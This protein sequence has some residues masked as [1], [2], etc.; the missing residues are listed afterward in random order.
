MDGSEGIG[1]RGR[2]KFGWILGGVALGVLV[3]LVVAGPAL[4]SLVVAPTGAVSSHVA[5][6][7][8]SPGTP[9]LGVHSYTYA[10]NTG[11]TTSTPDFSAPAGS[12]VFVFVGYVNPTI[13]GGYITSISDSS[14][15]H[16]HRITTT[17]LVVNHTESVYYAGDVAG[18]ST[19]SVSVS[20]AGGDTT[21]GGTVAAVDV[22]GAN[23]LPL[24]AYAKQ[25]GISSKAHV[26]VTTGITGELFLFGTVGRGLAAPFTTGP[27]EHLLDTSGGDCGPFADGVGFA[28]FYSENRTG[29]FTLSAGLY[30]SSDW[31]A[32]AV[33]VLPA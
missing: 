3:S 25:S 12:A 21:M 33:G 31:D 16:F 27:R 22:V 20:F 8:L 5:E 26:R 17:G 10:L 28:T 29:I 15:D 11:P 7:A 18:S 4:G 6:S 1:S 32:V 14:G 13:G 9:K 30:E 23:P 24:G 19:L 2:R